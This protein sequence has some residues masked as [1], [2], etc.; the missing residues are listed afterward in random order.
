MNSFNSS[1]ASDQNVPPPAKT[2]GELAFDK[3]FIVFLIKSLSPDGPELYSDLVGKE[4]SFSLI[5]SYKTSSLQSIYT[6]PGLPEVEILN[7]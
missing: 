6:G 2:I 5:F 7:A 3:R 1:E 4:E